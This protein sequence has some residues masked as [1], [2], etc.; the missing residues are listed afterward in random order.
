MTFAW[1]GEP[2]PH[3]FILRLEYWHQ[4]SMLL[5]LAG[6]ISF[7]FPRI[8]GENTKLRADGI[9]QPHIRDRV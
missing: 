9:A 3:E 5:I 1:H 4:D 6:I 8:V 2:E 7:P